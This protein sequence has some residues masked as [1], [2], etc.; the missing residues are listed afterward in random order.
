MTASLMEER[1]IQASTAMVPVPPAMIPSDGPAWA[2]LNSATEEPGL[3][4]YLR[5]PLRHWALI[6]GVIACALLTGLLFGWLR[7]PL[8]QGKL[9]LQVQAQPPVYVPSL[10]GLDSPPDTK[11]F[12]TT[13]LDI[14]R[15]RAVAEAVA[16]RLTPEQR[17]RLRAPS[18]LTKHAKAVLGGLWSQMGGWIGLS[19]DPDA[20]AIGDGSE[21][22]TPTDDPEQLQ[23]ALVKIISSNLTVLRREDSQ[24][25]EIYY[26]A[27]TPELAAHIANLVGLAYKAT[28]ESQQVA[29]AQQ[30]HEWL[31]GQ[32]DKLR[33]NLA[34]SE[35]ALQRFKEG[36]G[37]LASENLEALKSRRLSSITEALLSARA[38]RL[39]T[40]L[41]YLQV[42]EAK[43]NGTLKAV[44]DDP[45][46]QQLK[47]EQ[48]RLTA[49]L[50]KL[51]TRYG[52]KRLEI[53]ALQAQL[54]AVTVQLRAEI[55][56][57][58]QSIQKQYQ[59]AKQEVQRLAQAEENLNQGLRER[60]DEE[61]ILGKLERE[62]STNR[63]L[64]EAFQ[65]RIKEITLAGSM[66]AIGIRMLA[67]ALPPETPFKPDFIRILGIAGLFSMFG[68]I[69]LAFLVENLRRTFLTPQSVEQRLHLRGLGVVPR[70]ARR[71]SAA[72]SRPAVLEP[73][74]GLTEALGSIRTRLQMSGRKGGPQLLLVTSALQG[75]GKSMLSSNLAT[76]Y[77]QLGLTLLVDADLRRASRFEKCKSLGLTDFA[78]SQAQLVDCA[79][80]SYLSPNLFIM[81]KGRALVDP[82]EFFSSREVERAFAELRKYFDKIIV[83]TAPVLRVSDVEMMGRYSDG[84]V[85]A[86]QS[87]KTPMEAVSEAARRLQEA[88]VHVL[89]VTLTQANLKEVARYG[90]YGYGY[91]PS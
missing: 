7:M 62:V 46:V 42:Q 67:R 32:L 58:V 22:A 37:L 71:R 79:S 75:E 70:V 52:G 8:Y 73:G 30:V 89:G 59:R 24:L 82:L 77:S 66:G 34:A 17:Q 91:Q 72:L 36:Q 87:G 28:Q 61:L 56:R 51:R 14:I 53:Q 16:V 64:Y 76:S 65:S 74:A 23:R 48:G 81:S 39:R 9:L 15:S 27:P 90:G 78:L 31:I 12:Y 85:F 40:E 3:L 26:L 5:V 57:A 4:D 33:A 11:M 20:A 1:P 25:V 45:A 63:E 55:G 80:K 69:A 21:E 10:Q 84:A 44:I 47:M 49:E 88:H 50:D 35:R 54:D 29:V 19:D 43:R 86:V 68:A 6:I 18:E 2:G 41:Q 60:T 38:A 83:D 13:Q